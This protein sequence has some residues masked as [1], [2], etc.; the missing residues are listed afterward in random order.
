MK[1]KLTWLLLFVFFGISISIAQTNSVKGVVISGEDEMPI[2]G[3][4]ILVKGTSQGTITDF[5]G[6][7]DFSIPADAKTL[8]VSYVGMETQEVPIQPIM[9]IIMKSSSKALDE[10]V[11]VAYG[12]A[13]KSVFTGSAASVDNSK[14]QTPSA[15]FDKSLQGQVAGLQVM[16]SSG[17]PGSTSSFRIRGSGSL[18]ASN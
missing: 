12:T 13:K 4:S 5:D 7:F 8:V 16:S 9:K 11:V 15:S 1:R 3:A 10:V 14:I 18:N 2:I 6:R 17:Q